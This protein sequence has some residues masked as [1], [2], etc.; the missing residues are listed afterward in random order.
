MTTVKPDERAT[1]RNASAHRLLA[2]VLEEMGRSDDALAR[3]QQAVA[4]TPRDAQ[5][6]ADLGTMLLQRGRSGDAIRHFREALA[7]RA[8]LGTAHLGLGTALAAVGEQRGARESLEKAI[9]LEPTNAHG[10]FH[11][12]RAKRFTRD[13]RHFIAMQRLAQDM[14]SLSLEAQIYLHFALGKAFGDIEDYEQSFYH[15][16]EGNTLKRQQW[17]YREAKVLDRLKRVGA[18]FTPEIMREKAGLGEPSAVPVFIVGMHRSGSTLVE[19]ILASHP[20]CF[21]A[22]EL[23]NIDALARDLRG[24]NGAVF[25]EAVP[26]LS[27]QQLRALAGRYLAAIRPLSATAERITDKMP[28]NFIHAG[29][30]HLLFPKAHIIHTRRD[31]CDTAISCFGIVLGQAFLGQGMDYSSDLAELGRF[32]RAYRSL[33]AHWRSVLPAGAMLEVNYEELVEDF[34]RQARRIVAHC[35][36][37]WDD[38]CASFYRNARPV[39]TASVGQVH[40]PIY[41]SS[42]GRWRRYE[43]FMQPFIRALEGDDPPASAPSR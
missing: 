43:K 9:E 32:Y 36:L 30:I 35:G 13:D 21:G 1:P 17:P 2:A 7:L 22:G 42:V 24:P 4:L 16:L 14:R 33:M 10:Y 29:F 19:Q 38:A 18:M 8:D 28:L 20:K 40:Q 34:E 5:A 11:L 31:P 27:A 3:L 15:L 6:H 37:E 23:P 39:L 41:S 12:G 26:S 25:P